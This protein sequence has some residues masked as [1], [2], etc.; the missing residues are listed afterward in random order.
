M[1]TRLR[2]KNRDLPETNAVSGPKL[3][4]NG[5]ICRDDMCNL[6]ITARRLA[7]GHQQNRLTGRRHL[8]IPHHGAFGEN[9]S[10][11][12]FGKRNYRS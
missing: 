10:I 9:V 2:L 1:K 8:D 6:C 12:S 5:E 11:A 7:V 3:C 4:C